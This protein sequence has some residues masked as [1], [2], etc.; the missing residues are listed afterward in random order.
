MPGG[1]SGFSCRS[2]DVKYGI[3]NATHW[4]FPRMGPTLYRRLYCRNCEQ[5]S[6]M[7]IF[8]IMLKPDKLHQYYQKKEEKLDE[9]EMT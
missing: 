6:I 1:S 5:N 8:L 2:W 9:T 4:I 7:I 3:A